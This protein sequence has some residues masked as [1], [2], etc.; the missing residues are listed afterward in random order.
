MAITTLDG[1][2]AGMKSPIP[3]CKNGIAMEGVGQW[4]SPF[5]A[6]GFPGAA[7][8]PSPG[9]GGAALTS[10]AGQI[11]IPAASGNTHL[12]RLWVQASSPG[13]LLLCDRLWH[14]SGIAVTTTTG[15][16]VNSV[17]WP[18]R[19]QNGSTNGVGVMV[20]LEVSTATTNAAANSTMTITYT[21]DAGT[22]SRTG[23]VGAAIPMAFPATATVGTFVPFVLA[24]GDTGVRSVQTV[25][26]AVSLGAGA[27]HL[28]AYRILAQVTVASANIGDAA[29]LVS[30]GMPRCYDT[31]VPFLLWIPTATTATQIHGGVVFTQG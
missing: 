19:D 12:A 18:A 11:P 3:F 23:T 5:Y 14:Q 27:V 21:N 31:T 10:Y 16:T 24:A 30:L 8:A 1:A 15:Q 2:I 28:V 29:D 17:T 20:G 6:A 25:T 22:G 26:L 13:T 7:V 4:Y 9:M